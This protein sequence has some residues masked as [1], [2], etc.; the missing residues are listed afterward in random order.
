MQPHVI[1]EQRFQWLP[2]RVLVSQ[3]GVYCIINFLSRHSIESCVSSFMRGTCFSALSCHFS[4][5]SLQVPSLLEHVSPLVYPPS[6]RSRKGHGDGIKQKLASKRREERCFLLR[7]RVGWYCG[8]DYSHEMIR[9]AL[10]IANEKHETDASRITEAC[11]SFMLSV[12]YHLFYYLLSCRCLY[13]W[14]G[15]SRFDFMEWYRHKEF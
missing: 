6:F 3:V 1:H 8:H 5:R 9:P 13:T 2:F 12:N 15:V 7:R 4:L 10:R 14:T 11:Y